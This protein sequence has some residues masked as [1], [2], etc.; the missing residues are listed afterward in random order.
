M[1]NHVQNLFVA[2]ALLAL[3]TLNTQ[4]STAFAQ[5]TA[6][7]YQGQLQ[8]NGNPASG[9]FNLTF[10]LFNTNTT[11]VAIAG[12]VTNTAVVIT[13]GLFTVQV[14][15]GPGVFTGTNYWL[16]I[17]VETNGASPF[18]TLAPRQQLTPT[19]YAIYSRNAGIATTANSVASN[20][21]TGTNIATGQVVKSLNGLH[22]AVTLAGGANILVLPAG[23]N[24][25]IASTASGGGATTNAWNLTGNSGT[26]PGVDF[27]GTT[28]DQDLELKVDGEL[29]LSLQPTE[30]ANEPNLIGGSSLNSAGGFGDTIA[31]GYQN[32]IISN[33]GF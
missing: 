24:I 10:T 17:G 25:V 27:I 31:G 32:G 29:A 23:N 22:D 11:G 21:V 13:N 4:L 1:K 6:F 14:D 7:T 15:F 33:Y 8:N 2:L 16:Q 30:F 19:P 18:T 3:S 20:S 5:G 28:D 26:T 12:P 9:T